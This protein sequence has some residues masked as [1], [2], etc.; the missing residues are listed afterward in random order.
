[1]DGG[2]GS[3]TRV[4]DWIRRSPYVRRSPFGLV[5]RRPATG[6]SRDQLSASRLRTDS[7]SGGPARL[8]DVSGTAS[9]GPFRR[10]ASSKVY[11]RGQR[12]FRVGRYQ[13]SRWINE[14][15][16]PRHAAPRSP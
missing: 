16:G 1:L 4:R 15:P 7:A 12:Q 14:V 13:V 10:R 6:R 2:G 9:G 11:L 5:P 3:R 8:V